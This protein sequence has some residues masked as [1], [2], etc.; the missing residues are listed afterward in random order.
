MKAVLMSR[1]ARRAATRPCQKG[2]FK[3]RRNVG[4]VSARELAHGQ[5]LA[6]KEVGPAVVLATK[7]AG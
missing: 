2:G 7:G 1:G 5:G 6:W 4:A 3:V